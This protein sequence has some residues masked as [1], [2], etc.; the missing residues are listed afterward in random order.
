MAP[1]P[2][3]LNTN[4][5]V[6]HA[7]TEDSGDSD[8]ASSAP[9]KQ[10]KYRHITAWHKISRHSCL[11]EDSAASPSFLGFRNLLVLVLKQ[12][13]VL[14]CFSCHD[15]R[16][17]DLLLGAALYALVPCHLFIAFFIEAASAQQ[18]KEALGSQK[19]S[20]SKQKTI[21]NTAV[22]SPW[23]VIA[24]AHGIN[25][26]FCL[27]ITSVVVYFYINHPLIGTISEVHALIVW[28]KISSYALTNRDLRL[29]FIS[30]DT[31]DSPPEIYAACPYPLNITLTNLSYFWWAPTL[32]YQPVYP[33]SP[34]TRWVYVAKR[35]AEFAG[36]SA[37]IWLA[38][39]QYAAPIL[40]NSLNNMTSPELSSILERLTKL[41]TVSVIIWLAGF[42]AI[43]QSF[44]NAL[45]EIMQ[46]GDREF[47]TEW[48]NSPSVGVYWRTWNKPVN[49]FMC[50]HIYYPLIGRG[51]GQQSASTI[52]FIFSGVLHELMVGIPTHN[53]IGKLLSTLLRFLPSKNKKKETQAQALKVL[54]S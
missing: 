19:R 44:L 42:F 23:P 1:K 25:A 40:R 43:F 14:I 26:T 28:L 8:K 50:R 11:S 24:I 5:T 13:G 45:A 52:V 3:S 53:I 41:S 10:N 37:F 36:L 34:P 46:F 33:R 32:V 38:S 54:H 31:A 27:L 7:H 12:Y 6:I 29:A 49:Q 35:T 15:Y 9:R 18:V 48:W 47:Y 2:V 39:A 4:G 51:W 20:E 21:L 17:Q 16:A 30:Q 22:L